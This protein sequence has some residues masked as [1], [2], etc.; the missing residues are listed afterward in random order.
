MDL[1]STN[2]LAKKMR[3]SREYVVREECEMMILKEILESKYGKNLVFKGGT[4]LR[5]A[6]GSVRFSEDL[7][8]DL[9]EDFERKDFFEFVNKIVSKY[10]FIEEVETA[11][12][13]N[14]IF[15]VFKIKIPYLE[16]GFSIKVEISK[17]EKSDK[18]NIRMLRSETTNLTVLANVID[19]LSI[20]RDKKEAMKNRKKA[21]DVFDYWFINQILRKDVT[22]NFSGYNKEQAKAEL[23][24]L[25]PSDYWRVC[26][27]WLT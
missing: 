2:E 27:V 8:F 10:D 17:R 4:A 18:F 1:A 25:L 6:Y 12:K 26:D 24:K 9:V 21:R 14:T 5:L 11:D 16:R 7:D 22:P 20:L 19:V 13:K 15:A 3:I 23:H